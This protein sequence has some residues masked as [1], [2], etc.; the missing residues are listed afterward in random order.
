MGGDS[1]TPYNDQS[2]VG[3]PNQNMLMEVDSVQQ[4]ASPFLIEDEAYTQARRTS[5]TKYA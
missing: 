5:V 1:V 2:G 3:S 4:S